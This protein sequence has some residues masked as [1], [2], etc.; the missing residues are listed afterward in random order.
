MSAAEHDGL[1]EG[2]FH[3]ARGWRHWADWVLLTL[4]VLLALRGWLAPGK[5]ASPRLEMV[6][7][8]SII[9]MAKERLLQS[10]PLG[11]WVTFEFAGFP[12]VRFLAYPLYDGMAALSI[13]TGW[14]LDGIFKAAFVLAFVA[15][16]ITFYELAYAFTLRRGAAL[17]GGVIYALFPFHLHGASEAWI[18]AVSWALLPLLFLAYESSRGWERATPDIRPRQGVSL[19]LLLGV[20]PVVSIEYTML[21]APFL[22]LYLVLREGMWLWRGREAIPWR[23]WVAYW[24]LAG[25]TAL[26]LAAF[27]VLPALMELEYVGIHL[28]HGAESFQSHELLRD[29]AVAPALVW[30]AVVR[31]WG[32]DLNLEHVPVI[33][34]AFWSIAWYPGVIAGGLALLGLPW[35]RR[36]ARARAML[37]L[38]LVALLFV[39]GSWFPWNPFPYLPFVGR[40]SAFRGVLFVALAGA[41]L[42][43]WGVETL[44]R[45]RPRSLPAGALV[46]ALLILT[47]ADYM[48]AAKA[49]TT[50]PDYF[51]TDELAAYRWLG[52]QSSDQGNRSFEFTTTH[53]G[54]YLSSYALQYDGG[55][56]L[57][58]Y[59]DNGAPRHMWALL[60]WGDVPA[61]LRLGSTRYVLSR[62]E[63]NGSNPVFD[64]ILTAGYTERVWE[65]AHLTIWETPEPQ[66]FVHVY[67]DA[68]FYLG[69]PEYR[70]LDI[71]PILAQ[72]DVALVSGRSDYADDYDLA[73]LAAFGAL[74]VRPPW[75]RDLQVQAA[76]ESALSGR[77][78]THQEILDRGWATA[79][80]AAMPPPLVSW[81]RP[82]PERIEV[83]VET[84]APA[85]VMVSEA[86]YPNWRVEVDGVAQP[87]WRVN[88]AFLGAAV[89][90]GRHTLVFR[91]EKPWYVWLGYAIT[92]LT[93]LTIVGGLWRS[94]PEAAS[95]LAARRTTQTRAS[96]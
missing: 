96:Q 59:Y 28:K 35:L 54:T 57:W 62:P 11:E 89:A 77:V 38:L 93:L 53:R 49:L 60:S 20:M 85:V 36:D 2:Q 51:A 68:A 84:A 78:V 91:Y 14:S 82:H 10:G 71:L 3:A 22:G 56:H 1:S 13:L 92:G 75:V 46:G 16:A 45:W 70:A 73:T 83:T 30:R 40:L 86:W 27:F 67:D 74:I 44:L 63:G 94:R 52:A 21:T 55:R 15:S 43:G 61:A 90:A 48:P 64:R 23:R 31:R 26:G 25:L 4:I 80:D 12:Y 41:L 65:S 37:A 24:A 81:Q 34:S 17:V 5:I 18:H 72:Q 6:P 95:S 58:G 76:V 87:V 9:W 8:L 33:G 50:V 47:F 66:P 29:Y 32:G 7:E 88:Y 19:G 42:A 79:V 39:V 69:D